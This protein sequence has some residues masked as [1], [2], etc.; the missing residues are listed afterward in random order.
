MRRHGSMESQDII[1]LTAESSSCRKTHARVADL[2][3]G[4]IEAAESRFSR[5]SVCAGTSSRGFSTI[6]RG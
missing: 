3:D 1:K 6:A 5:A 4:V 2:M